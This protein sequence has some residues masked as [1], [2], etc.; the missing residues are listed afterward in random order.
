M[1]AAGKA[2]TVQP[3][4]TPAK[5]IS[6]AELAGWTTFAA[7]AIVGGLLFLAFSIAVIRLIWKRGSKR[8]SH[9]YRARA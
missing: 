2:H 9:D 6:D 8:D 3:T 4:P 1:K 5:T 7:I